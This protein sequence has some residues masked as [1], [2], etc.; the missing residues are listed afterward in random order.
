MVLILAS[1]T[2]SHQYDVPCYLRGALTTMTSK[3]A[4]SNPYITE[5]KEDVLYH[6]GI[7]YTPSDPYIVQQ[8]SDVKYVCM[9]GSALRSER[10]AHRAAFE[11]NA[12]PPLGTEL[13][14]IGKNERYVLYKVRSMPH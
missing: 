2:K 11:L 12:C 13:T 14:T 7:S 6:I 3:F 9:S 10:L 8:F 1:Y 4:I 5:D